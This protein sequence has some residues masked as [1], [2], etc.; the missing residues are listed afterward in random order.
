MND[1]K[2]EDEKRIFDKY[3][4]PYTGFLSRIKTKFIAW[5]KKR[6]IKTVSD[7]EFMD[8]DLLIKIVCLIMAISF[9]R[10]LGSLIYD[11]YVWFFPQTSPGES[12]LSPYFIP[13]I[14]AMMRGE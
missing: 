5:K 3:I 11:V 4:K 8:Y 14:K 9:I 2:D 12:S 7:F 13:V 10:A 6:R 1:L